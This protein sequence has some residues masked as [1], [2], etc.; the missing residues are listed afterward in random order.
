[1]APVSTEAVETEVVTDLTQTTSPEVVV[2]L[3]M[4]RSL[5]QLLIHTLQERQ[6]LSE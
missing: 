1:V 6:L 2:R 5:L 4:Q 3:E